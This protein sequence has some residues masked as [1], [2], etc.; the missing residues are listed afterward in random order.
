VVE[1][2]D[3]HPDMLFVRH[4]DFVVLRIVL[5][6]HRLVVSFRLILAYRREPGRTHKWVADLAG[7][8]LAHSQLK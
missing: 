1:R 4:D 6:L 2:V 7:I 8:E 5:F 3:L